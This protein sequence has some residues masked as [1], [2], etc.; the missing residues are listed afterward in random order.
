MN[1]EAQEAQLGVDWERRA[2]LA[3]ARLAVVAAARKVMVTCEG[4]APRWEYVEALE[5]LQRALEA[6][7]ALD[8]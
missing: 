4:A 7:E 8:D 6:L 5:G 3:R 1:D 2:K